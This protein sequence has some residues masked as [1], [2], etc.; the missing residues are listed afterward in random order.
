MASWL[1][2]GSGPDLLLVLLV[3]ILLVR[4]LL[5]SCLGAYLDH[6]L[7]PPRPRPPRPKRD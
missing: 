5:W 3:V 2:D 1:G 7:A 6:R 4:F